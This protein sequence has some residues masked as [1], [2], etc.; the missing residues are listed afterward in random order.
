VMRIAYDDN[1]FAWQRFGG[2]S[3]YFCE[4][5]LR[6]SRMG[7]RVDVIAPL[8]GNRHL[9]AARGELSVRGAFWSTMGADRGAVRAASRVVTQVVLAAIQPDILHETYYSTVPYRLLSARRIVTVHDMIHELFPQDFPRNDATSG[10]KR[11]AV[12]EADHVICVSERTRSD[13]QYR[14]GVPAAKTSVVYL[15]SSLMGRGTAKL[16][17]KM[18]GVDFLLYVGPRAG[19]KNFDRVVQAYAFS[20]FLR[21]SFALV[22][23]GSEPFSAQERSRHLQLQIEPHKIIHLQGDDDTLRELYTQAAALVFPSL[24]EGFGIPPLEAMGLGCPV[25][26]S[27]AGSIGEV[28]GT[29]AEPFD[30]TNVESIVA[31]LERVVGNVGYRAELVARG[32][33]RSAIFSW[34]KCAQ[35]T[36]ALYQ[37]VL[38]RDSA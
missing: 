27:L 20:K 9:E 7:P 16:A 2:I 28:V 22:A 32:K 6:L 4:L 11:R 15:G 25:V 29:A 24:Y 3:R 17:E 8:Y 35:Q 12:E 1:V 36:L 33:E 26:C 13:L 31:A 19:Y 23:F 10:A 30:P 14:W 34:D 18:P 21:D 37:N 38:E 5:A